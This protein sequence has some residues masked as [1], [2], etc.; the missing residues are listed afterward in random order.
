[1]A[2]GDMKV[3]D[4]TFGSEAEILNRPPFRAT[5]MTVDFAGVTETDDMG[6]KVIKG[7]TPI[8]KDGKPVTATPWTGA[9]GILHYDVNEDYPQGHILTEAYVNVTRANAN[10]GLTYDGALVTAMNKAGNRIKLEE[11]DVIAS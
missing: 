3:T 2:R 10:S 9:I 7:G 1:M 8:D 11:P 5:S 6:R 4:T